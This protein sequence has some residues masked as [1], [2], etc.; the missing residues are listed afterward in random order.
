M[1]L[2]DAATALAERNADGLATVLAT[3]ALTE[4]FNRCLKS[5][6]L[7]RRVQTFRLA[8]A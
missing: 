6:G 3:P 7:Q 1:V 4:I 8:I 2:V 5:I